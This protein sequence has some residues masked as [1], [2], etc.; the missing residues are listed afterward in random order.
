MFAVCKMNLNL[1]GLTLPLRFC[2][3]CTCKLLRYFHAWTIFI[4]LVRKDFHLNLQP[5]CY[6]Y[7]T[8]YNSNILTLTLKLEFLSIVHYK[9]FY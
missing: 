3:L 6:I 1:L 5:K 7:T 4:L 9:L 8:G 2:C